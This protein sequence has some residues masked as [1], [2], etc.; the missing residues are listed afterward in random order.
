MNVTWIN[1]NIEPPE[2]GEYYIAA[3][4]LQ[5][6]DMCG[7]KKGDIEIYT[8][9][10]VGLSS[11]GW[12]TIG[13]NSPYWKVVCWARIIHPDIPADMRDRVIRYF[14]VDVRKNAEGE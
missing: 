8:D 6:N 12:D 1:G 11:R 7:V 10:Y 13:K 3:E 2:M 4:A 14:G 9:Y 5:D